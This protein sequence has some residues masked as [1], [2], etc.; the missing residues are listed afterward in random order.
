MNKRNIQ[1][2]ILAAGKSSRIYPFDNNGHKSMIRIMGKPIIYYTV[3]AL[4]KAGVN[5]LIIV[6]SEKSDIDKYFNEIKKSGVLIKYVIQNNPG[7]MGDALL[8]SKRYIKGDFF[9]LNA[10]HVDVDVFVKKLLE[11]KEKNINAVLLAKK[12]SIGSAYG[13][14]RFKNKKVEEIIEKPK[15]GEEPSKM[16]VIGIYL[17]DK[18]FLSVLNKVPKEHYQLEKAISIYAKENIVTFVKIQ[19]NT[20]TL[21]YP[22]DL[23]EVKNYL[24]ERLNRSISKKAKIAKSAEIIGDVVIEE[25]AT[26]MEGVRIK[27]NCYIGRN[28]V[29]GNNALLRNCVDVEENCVIG[30]YME[31]KN[32]LVMRG[33]T[34]HS[35]FIGD[36]IIGEN[37]KIAAQFCT[38]N[39]RI[40][41]KTVGSVVKGEKVETGKKYLGAMIG[42]NTNIGI[43]AS[44]MPGVLIGRNVF[45]GPSTVV[46]KNIPDNTKYYTKFKEY[47]SKKNE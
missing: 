31:V 14:L 19:E 13:V 7:G 18:S 26:I 17:F 2:V 8:L 38:G 10:Y 32:S 4:R 1:A 45:I 34:T 41:R 11:A 40:D 43:K 36:S 28:A 46:M 37:C 9:L 15:K 3:E 16:C 6:G 39:V 30:S 29:I 24:F 23:L 47:V 5:D 12:R 27:G 33:A 42:S 21:K 20:V 35:G 44:T 22:W 25:G